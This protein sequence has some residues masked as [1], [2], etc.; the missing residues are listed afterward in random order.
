MIEAGWCPFDVRFLRVT[1]DPDI[2]AFIFSLGCTSASKDHRLCE[3]RYWEGGD[4]CVA[5][6]IG[7]KSLPRHVEPHCGCSLIGPDMTYI[8]TAVRNGTIP[9]IVLSLPQENTE[10][11]D[12]LLWEQALDDGQREMGKY[13][14]FSHVWK[15]GLGNPDANLLPKCQVI[16]IANLLLELESS[17]QGK[18][19]IIEEYEHPGR[20]LTVPFWIDTFCVPVSPQSQDLRNICIARMRKIYESA[21][22]VIALD[23]DLQRLSSDASPTK[24]LGHLLSCSWRSRQWT[25]Q[26]GNLAWDLLAPAQGKWFDM[27]KILD[28]YELEED[29]TDGTAR[30]C[31][32]ASMTRSMADVSRRLIRSYLAPMQVAHASE[33]PLENMLR[34]LAHRTTSR[35]GDEAIC[36]ATFMNIDPAPILAES[37]P[38]DRMRK[39]LGC[40]PVLSKAMLFAYGPRFQEPGFRWAPE[41]FLAP[42]GYR[43]DL[44]F[45]VKYNPTD[46]SDAKATAETV[47]IPPPYLCPKGHGIVAIFSG[48]KLDPPASSQSLPQHFIVLTSLS[49][50]E[51][52][53][54]DVNE[55]GVNSP[56]WHEVCEDS[57]TEW[58]VLFANEKQLRHIPDALLVKWLGEMEDGQIRCEWKYEV[59]VEK[60]DDCVLGEARKKALQQADNYRGHR[61]PFREWVID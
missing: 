25:Y 13:F 5:D 55:A 46:R 12:F 35:D 6:S 48:I 57:T 52:F 22:A 18:S 24:F 10:D 50:N 11:V 30:G 58:A 3:E 59:M 23:P 60:F 19:I 27:D 61:I 49:E 17:E 40:L 47:A 37:S 42:H 2:T 39:L 15:E 9:L 33:T 7:M 43:R 44:L 14:A 28:L 1:F 31:I 4:H 16:R 53:V 34:A 36:I 41:T 45:P 56:P 8:E 54:I 51:G 29:I 20:R 32:E 21:T 26:E 38:K